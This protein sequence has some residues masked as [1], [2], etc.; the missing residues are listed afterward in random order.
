[1]RIITGGI[2]LEDKPHAKRLP[3]G[4]YVL[5]AKSPKLVG[6]NLSRFGDFSIEFA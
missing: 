6:T 2:I 4:G 5:T 1:M 3:Q